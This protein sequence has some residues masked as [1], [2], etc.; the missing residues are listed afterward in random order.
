MNTPQMGKLQGS[1]GQKAITIPDVQLR[2]HE[3]G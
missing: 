1:D 2:Q 3:M